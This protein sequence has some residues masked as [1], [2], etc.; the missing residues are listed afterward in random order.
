MS[1]QEMIDI[2]IAFMPLIILQLSLQLYS[3]YHVYKKSNYKNKH[4]FAI[5]IVV[6]NLIGVAIYWLIGE[7]EVV[8]N[9]IF[10]EVSDDGEF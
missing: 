2:L 4:I 6:L 10:E 8:S 1:E 5:L 7:K 9:S 3:I